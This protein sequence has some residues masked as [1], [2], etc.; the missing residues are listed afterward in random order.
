MDAMHGS[1]PI[2]ANSFDAFKQEIDQL[3]HHP[4]THVFC[5]I[6]SCL[7]NW[8]KRS[9]TEVKSLQDLAMR[10]KNLNEQSVTAD[11]KKELTSMIKRAA[12]QFEEILLNPETQKQKINEIK[13]LINEIKTFPD[14]Q[15]KSVS[16]LLDDTFIS[17]FLDELIRAAKPQQQPTPADDMKT[18][19]KELLDSMKSTVIPVRNPLWIIEATS[20][21]LSKSN[22]PNLAGKTKIQQVIENDVTNESI[23]SILTHRELLNEPLPNGELP[24][25]YAIRLGK[26]TATQLLLLAGS[27]PLKLDRNHQSAISLAISLDNDEILNYLKTHL[28]HYL[29]ELHLTQFIQKT[30]PNFQQAFGALTE[31]EQKEFGKKIQNHKQF[32]NFCNDQATELFEE[33]AKARYTDELA[34]SYQEY[35]TFCMAMTVLILNGAGY[36]DGSL[37][38][39]ATNLG[40]FS[41]MM[42]FAPMLMEVVKDPQLGQ[43]LNIGM[44]FARGMAGSWIGTLANGVTHAIYGASILETVK[45]AFC[46]SRV[47]TGAALR[48]LTVGTVNAGAHAGKLFDNRIQMAVTGLIKSIS[49]LSFTSTKTFIDRE[50]CKEEHLRLF[51]PIFD[52]VSALFS[53]S[54]NQHPE[55]NISQA[56]YQGT[57]IGELAKLINER[58]GTLP[59]RIT[60]P[61]LA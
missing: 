45:V 46:N 33:Q 1:R 18:M 7:A 29:G 25:H 50:E 53:P 61:L 58:C 8:F 49:G 13:T 31:Q 39:Y 32:Q 15:T 27:S 19:V 5:K 57:Q 38:Y 48:R 36:G 6:L 16:P 21:F 24:L 26:T 20:K 51:Q 3:T 54:N 23:Q 40:A 22:D 41:Q 17:H 28:S 11:Q 12:S 10:V 34:S 60:M 35:I 2:N 56:V 30:P 37:A 55:A 42:S 47:R 14:Q 4:I 43:F 9:E 52:S 59:A 44:M